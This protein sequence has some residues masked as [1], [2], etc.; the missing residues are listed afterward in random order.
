MPTLTIQTN[1]THRGADM[2]HHPTSPATSR[3]GDPA[4]HGFRYV[5]GA[6]VQRGILVTPYVSTHSLAPQRAAREAV[7]A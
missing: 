7:A 1:N 2:N 6:L 4:Y 5:A 3:P